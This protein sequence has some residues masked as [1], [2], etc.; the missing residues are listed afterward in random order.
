MEFGDFNITN[1]KLS[2]RKKDGRLEQEDIKAMLWLY[3]ETNATV[4]MIYRS[5]KVDR[6]T[7]YYHIHK[8]GLELRRPGTGNTTNHPTKFDRSLREVYQ[9]HYEKGRF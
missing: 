5:F 8:H 7:L 3:S 4:A 6:R 1:F 2:P 9:K